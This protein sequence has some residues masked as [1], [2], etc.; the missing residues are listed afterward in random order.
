MLRSVF[1]ARVRGFSILV[2]LVV[3]LPNT[4]SAEY[5]AEVINPNSFAVNYKLNGQE[6]SVNASSGLRHANS[7]GQ[8]KIEFDGSLDPGIQLQGWTLRPNSTQ[9][10][11]IAGDG[12][13]LQLICT[14]WDPNIKLP[15]PQNTKPVVA[16][17]NQTL[18]NSKTIDTTA[19]LYRS[20][21][22]VIESYTRSGH[23]TEGLHA[24]LFLVCMDAQGHAIWVTN[25]DKCTTRGG[26]LDWTTESAG[27]NTFQHQ[28]PP[29][30][31]ALVTRIDIYQST[32]DLG[33]TVAQWKHNIATA[34]KFYN[35]LPP[36]VKVM[37]AAAFAA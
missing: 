26:T 16:H 10:F 29:M 33:D 12:R 15:P 13:G 35:E 19:T 20:G 14:G 34:V 4:A 27:T 25:R 24:R 31:A 37:I 8:F 2:S 36:E 30:V 9:K 23:P 11:Q 17:K 6:Y 22:L 5:F 7:T 1:R 32:Q 21:Q 28:V 18:G 3:W